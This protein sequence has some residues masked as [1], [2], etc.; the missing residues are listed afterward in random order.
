MHRV[1]ALELSNAE[2]D[3]LAPTLRCAV[4]AVFAP[5]APLKTIL[6][7]LKRKPKGDSMASIAPSRWPLAGKA[8][9]WRKRSGK[10]NG[11]S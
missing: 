11:L 6:A 8:I 10:Y 1:F 2:R 7:N 9:A 3:A 5:I 4:D